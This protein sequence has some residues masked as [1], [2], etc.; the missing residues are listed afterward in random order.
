MNRIKFFSYILLLTV[1]LA[2]G[3]CSGDEPEL[4][5]SFPKSALRLSVNSNE[6]LS[7][8][9]GPVSKS[10]PSGI[11]VPAVGEFTVSFTAA[12]ETTPQASYLYS[13]MPEIIS[14]PVGDYRILATCGENLPAAWNTPYFSGYTT[15]SVVASDVTL[16]DPIV[17]TIANTR[18]SIVFDESIASAMSADSKVDLSANGTSIAVTPSE[19]ASGSIFVAPTGEPITATFR[20]QINGSP[21]TATHTVA[22]PLPTHHYRII[23]R[24]DSQIHE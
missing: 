6:A 19:A 9:G 4:Q 7:A 1:G 16:A 10:S 13:E 18:V 3:S 21:V 20:G 5:G 2:L 11:A 22:S 17:C 23:F 24:Y 12:G 8:I 14:L 15:T